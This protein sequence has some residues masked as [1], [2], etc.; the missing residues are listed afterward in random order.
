MEIYDTNIK[1][2]LKAFAI[3]NEMDYFGVASVDRFANL[4]EGHRPTDMLPTAKSVIVLGMKLA[5]GVILAHE[6]AFAGNTIPMP[7]FTQ[8]GFNKPSEITNIAAL[9]IV[10]LLEKKYG[11]V[12][13]PIPSGEPHDELLFMGA[14][15]NRYAALCAGL[16]EMT[17]SGFVATPDAGPRVRWVSVI[18]EQALEPDHLYNGPRLCNPAKCGIC[19]Q[20]CPV[21][22]LSNTESVCVKIGEF[23]TQ[24]AKR[25]KP[26]CRCAT[27]GL[28][29]GTPGR[30][31]ADMPE[32]METMEDWFALNKTNDHWGK[33]EF[34]H[35][36]YCLRCMTQC[37]IGNKNI[38]GKDDTL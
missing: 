13:M 28:V 37:P 2:E 35:G 36:N 27:S 14:M 6:E 20:C 19:V 1:D 33:A 12:T 22:A 21:H 3:A 11:K 8:F 32:K 34:H 23:T 18:T 15:S 4:P 16:G 29:K 9:K 7:A 10:R 17:W 24:Y 5:S 26:R 31:Q 30:L 25:D 38:N